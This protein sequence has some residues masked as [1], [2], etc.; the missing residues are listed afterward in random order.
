[1][2]SS[3]Q[4]C[5]DGLKKTGAIESDPER[6]FAVHALANK[7]GKTL[8]ADRQRDEIASCSFWTGWLTEKLR[9]DCCT[10]GDAI[11]RAID[12]LQHRPDSKA[13]A[14]VTTSLIG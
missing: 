13:V 6:S 12:Y 3:L 2:T 1:M 9:L 4:D 11:L 7:I 5:H 8:S 10:S 14:R